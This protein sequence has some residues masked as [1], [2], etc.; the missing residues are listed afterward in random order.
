[1]ESR[2]D[3]VT[4]RKKS[5]W[6][7]YLDFLNPRPSQTTKER[8]FFVVGLMKVLNHMIATLLREKPYFLILDF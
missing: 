1:M 7:E 5:G 2:T 3:P 8:N 4:L 6:R